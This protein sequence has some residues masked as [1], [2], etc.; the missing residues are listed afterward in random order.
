MKKKPFLFILLFLALAAGTFLLLH[1][2]KKDF[3]PNVLIITLDTTRADHIGA[4]GYQ[5]AETPNIDRLARE[6]TIFRNCYAQVPL[7]LPS[8][9]TLFT[10]RYPMAHNVRNNAKYFLNNSE[11]TLAEALQAKK[12]QTF[13]VIAAFVLQSKFGLQQGFDFYDDMLNPHEIAHNF[14][15]EIPAQ[16]VYEKF[17]GWLVKNSTQKFLDRKSTRLNSS[18]T[19]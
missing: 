8:H 14:R 4:Y 11:F 10:G 15:S 3:E 7:T 16:E 12:Y 13:A 2:G 1:L 17:S 5:S 19:T 18:H 9:C 6:G